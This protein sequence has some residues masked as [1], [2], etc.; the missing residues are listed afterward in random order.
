MSGWKWTPR[1]EVVMRDETPREALAAA[2][3][4]ADDRKKEL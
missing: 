4:R 2:T 3:T 1:A